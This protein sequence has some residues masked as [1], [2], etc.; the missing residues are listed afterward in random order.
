MNGVIDLSTIGARLGYKI[1]VAAGTRPTSDYT[2]IPNPKSTPEFNPEPNMGETTSLNNEE[3]TT[4]IPLLKDLGGAL[5]FGVGMSQKL[6]DDWNNMCDAVAAA[7]A[8]G[9]SAWFTVYHPRLDKAVFFTGTPSKIG[10]PAMEVNAIWDTTVYIA[11]TNEPDWYTA[12]KPL[13]NGASA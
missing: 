1:E 2:N 12:V 13:D 3:Y 4:Y 11:P 7:E 6:L 10:M 5:A 9:K 8:D